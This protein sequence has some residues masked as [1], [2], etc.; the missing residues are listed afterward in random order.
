MDKWHLQQE[1]M[2]FSTDTDAT[3]E[4]KLSVLFSL[5]QRITVRHAKLLKLG[6]DDVLE[7]YNGYWVALRIRIW[8]DRSPV[9]GETVR[10]AAVVRKPVGNRA[11]WDYDFYVGEEHIGECTTAW[12]LV[13]QETGKSMDLDRIE[14]FPREDPENAT[15]IILSRIAFPVP[16]ELYDNRQLYYSDTDV[17]NH[18]N[19]A[20]YVDLACDAAELHLRPQG[21]FLQEVVISYIGE[22]KAG[23]IIKLYRG[24]GNGC[25]YIHGVG[26]DGSDRFD[27]KLRMSSDAGLYLPEEQG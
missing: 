1:S 2:I 18:V 4:C 22:C 27:C 7:K 6:R 17:N 20:R 9:W 11:Y 13:S 16:L 5:V 12:A 15:G 3:Y 23:E 8:L 10:I 24:K 21:V 25:L 19:N 26:P 14:E